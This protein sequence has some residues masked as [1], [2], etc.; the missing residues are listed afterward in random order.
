MPI[1]ND[2]PDVAVRIVQFQLAWLRGAGILSVVIAAIVA[3][4][5][6]ASVLRL[7][8]ATRCNGKV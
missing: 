6:F 2:V 8:S 3:T 4:G 5:V 1:L 7:V